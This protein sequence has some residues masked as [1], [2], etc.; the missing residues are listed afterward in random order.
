MEEE[1]NKW[2]TFKQSY[3]FY[4]THNIDIRQNRGIKNHQKRKLSNSF[5]GNCKRVFKLKALNNIIYKNSKL[6]HICT[7]NNIK[8]FI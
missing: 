8:R 3:T 6:F 2:K 4:I 7:F 5:N 1:N